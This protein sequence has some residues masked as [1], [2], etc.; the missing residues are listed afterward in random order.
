MRNLTLL[1]II[2]IYTSTILLAQ[3]DEKKQNRYEDPFE[4]PGNVIVDLGFNFLSDDGGVETGFWGSK[5]VGIYYMYEK[6][7]KDSH[8][9]INPGIGVSLEKYDFRDDFTLAESID[10]DGFEFTE[11]VALDSA[12]QAGTLGSTEIRKSKLAAE[13]IEIPLEFRYYQNKKN[14]DR[15]LRVA[16]GIKGGFL[17]TSRTKIKYEALDGDNVIL[18]EKNDFHLNGLRWS[19]FGRIGLGG[20]NLFYEQGLSNIFESGQGPLA[21]DARYFKVGISFIGF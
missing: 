16:I 15:G 20:L 11:F 4:V 9:S 18:K 17:F 6:T 7:W 1:F 21:T 8:F 12:F 2:V 5:S 13:Y 19:A 10:E 14:H 3:E